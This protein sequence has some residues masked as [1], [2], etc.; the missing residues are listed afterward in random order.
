MSANQNDNTCQWNIDGVKIVF[1]VED[2]KSKFCKY[3][4]FPAKNGKY[5]KRDKKKQM[6]VC[7]KL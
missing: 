6:K 1:I 3:F 7:C 5:I 2:S 4:G